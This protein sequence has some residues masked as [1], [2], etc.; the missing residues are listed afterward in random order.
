[1]AAIYTLTAN[2]SGACSASPYNLSQPVSV[3]APNNLTGTYSTST[4]TYPLQT[5]NFVRGGTINGQYNWGSV[6]NQTL[7]HSGSASWS[8]G[9]NGTFGFYITTG[10]K[11]EFKFSGISATCGTV[12]A[13]R[14]FLQSSFGNLVVT[15]SPVPSNGMLSVSIDQVPDTSITFEKA[16]LCLPQHSK[17][18]P[19]FSIL[20]VNTGNLIKQWT[21]QENECTNYNLNI[22]GYKAGIYI[23]KVERKYRTVNTKIIL[24]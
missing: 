4:N 7:T 19:R 10:Q 12:T 2:L 24:Q 15:A 21:Y 22:N 5:V 11:Y 6:T 17:K 16:Q 13:S 9:G 18:K 1:M 23:L 14:T 20:D 3:D 8:Y